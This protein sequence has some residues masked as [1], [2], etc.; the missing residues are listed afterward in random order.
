MRL[1]MDTSECDQARVSETVSGP[2]AVH[3]VS[4]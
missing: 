3:S 4:R 1:S 2:T